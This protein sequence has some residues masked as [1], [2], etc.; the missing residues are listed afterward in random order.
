ML[1]VLQQLP[2]HIQVD[3]G[4]R[5]GI[6][7]V[8]GF[9]VEVVHCL[10]HSA[11]VGIDAGRQPVMAVG[12]RQ[13]QAYVAEHDIILHLEEIMDTQVLVLVVE[14]VDIVCE[15]QRQ[16]LSHRRQLQGREVLW[17]E[18]LLVHFVHIYAG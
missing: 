4:L 9:A 18:F 2:S 7:G 1:A 16:N 14:E 13:L 5:Y 12:G 15:M 8:L 6:D 17:Q 3:C 10:D 11:E